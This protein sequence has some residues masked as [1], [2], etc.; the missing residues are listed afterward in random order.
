MADCPLTKCSS[1]FSC[2]T[3][4][5]GRAVSDLLAELEA[6]AD[7]SGQDAFLL[8]TTNPGLEDVVAAEF[9]QLLEAERLPGPDI[10]LR[11]FG[12]GGHVLVRVVP[13]TTP[14]DG[15]RLASRMRSIHHVVR[16]LYSFQFEPGA[17]APLAALA[18]MIL[19]RGI[20]DME[21][22]GSFRITSRRTGD[23]PFS[24]IDVQREAGAALVTRYGTPVDLV[25]FDLNV[26]V[27]VYGGRCNV[28]IQLTRTLLSQRFTRLYNPRATLRSN[29]AYAL[30][31][32]AGIDQQ[33]ESQPPVR[34]LDPFCGSGT[35]LFEASRLASHLEVVGSDLSAEAVDGAR[36]NMAAAGLADR[37]QI[38]CEDALEIGTTFADRNVRFIVTNPPYGIRL[39]RT[40]NFF[41]FYVRFL[42]QC[43]LLLEPGDRLAFIAWKRGVVD[44]A[45]QRSGQFAKLRARV[46]ETGGIYP[47]IYVMERR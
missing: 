20:P 13:P 12:F 3:R 26:R 28:G 34:L 16:P 25:D 15:W 31:H 38:G 42:D 46:V 18:S 44:R 27:D 19:E 1:P 5:G 43:A 23:H 36:S 7:D 17:D 33:T 6:A 21:V 47:R 10:D 11:P 2:I 29:V 24:K 8:F 39:G 45:N 37:I 14:G 9:R 32:L 35:I 22:A 41:D 30:L 40:L 4:A